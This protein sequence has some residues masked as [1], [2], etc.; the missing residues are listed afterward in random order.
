MKHAEYIYSLRSIY[1]VITL[2]GTLFLGLTGVKLFVDSQNSIYILFSILGLAGL[3]L[4]IY[5]IVTN[6]QWGCFV[7]DEGITWWSK[8]VKEQVDSLS[9]SQISEIQFDYRGEGNSI[10]IVCTDGN[11]VL[12]SSNYIGDG[13]AIVKALVRLNPDAKYLKI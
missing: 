1:G 2:V 6:Y 11:S 3:L 4:T 7:D 13:K 10:T 12:I 5:G 9:H 8:V